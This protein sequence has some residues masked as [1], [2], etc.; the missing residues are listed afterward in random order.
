VADQLTSAERRV[1]R[2]ELRAEARRLLDRHAGPAR[3]RRLLD[4]AAAPD[5]AQWQALATSGLVG[6][7]VPVELGG[8]G[9]ELSDLCVVLEEAGRALLGGPLLATAAAVIPAL[10]RLGPPARQAELLAEIV[11]GKRTATAALEVTHSL[12][13][14]ETRAGWK[15]SGTTGPV[16]DG[17]DADLLLVT[18]R[19]AEGIALFGVDAGAMGLERKPLAVVDPT[20][21]FARLLLRNTSAER[22][23]DEKST[24]EAEE[25]LLSIASLTISAEMLGTAR[26]C[27]DMALEYLGGRIAFD[28][29][30]S[31]FQALKHRCADLYVEITEAGVLLEGGLLTLAAAA[32]DAAL[33]ASLAKASA[34]DIV[35]KA[36]NQNILLHGGIGFT[37]DH[38]AHLYL[39][40][41][42]ACQNLFGDAD[43]H[44]RRAFRG[45][46]REVAG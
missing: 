38:D 16:L 22:L 26:R 19:T 3:A 34:G 29:P 2:E 46:R 20:R 41:A 39:R 45:I 36:A 15:L 4:P 7:Q 8:Q 6:I 30:L 25:D 13:A 27:L 11:S 9:G 10:L 35:L 23:A 37:Y 18:A 24:A 28:R 43:R 17:A 42:M 21:R 33:L 31:S 14:T 5:P 1:A 44:R 40:R 12:V 32:P